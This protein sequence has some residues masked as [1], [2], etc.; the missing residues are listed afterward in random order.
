MKPENR[1]GEEAKGHKFLFV[2]SSILLV[3][4]MVV[5]W[6]LRTFGVQGT[7]NILLGFLVVCGAIA[8]AIAYRF[9]HKPEENGG[10]Q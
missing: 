6:L 3:S 2:N 1:G 5:S 8:L 7:I 10:Q 4:L 9:L